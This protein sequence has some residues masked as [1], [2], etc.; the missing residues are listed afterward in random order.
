MASSQGVTFPE[1]SLPDAK[2]WVRRLAHYRKADDLRGI[3]EILVTV[4]P[5]VA[6][7]AAM[8]AA[9]HFGYWIGLV[10]A[11][12]AGGFL[13]RLFV[14]QH[15]CGHGAF[16]GRRLANDWT[17]RGISVLTLTP[18]DFWK[19]VHAMHHAGSGSLDRRGFGDITTLTV[20]EYRRLSTGQRLRYRLYRNPFVLFGIG[21]IYL[22]LFE[23]R[24]PFGMM[25][26]GWR[27]WA[28]TMGTNVAILLAVMAVIWLVGIK[29][30]F[31][32]QL[33][34]TTVAGA[35]GI[36]LF[37]VQHQFEGT[38]WEAGEDWN[39]HEAAFHG[40]SHYDLPLLLRWLTGNIGVHHVHHLCSRI[41]Y[42]RLSAVL[43]DFPELRNVGRLTLLQSIGCV[44]FALWDEQQHRLIS[45]RDER[46]GRQSTAQPA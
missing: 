17:G 46:I 18:Y 30:F 31:L 33:P 26:G 13:V 28:S 43:R 23:Q 21:P 24:L 14:I 44:R 32:I 4:G 1:A 12:P 5:L 37:F 38:T 27:P 19:R 16:F 40:S 6:F 11:I 7:W 9:L 29:L 45:F 8:W 39:W 10:L 25:G 3:F 35:I 34:I 2:V 20:G 36:W 22:F 15:D 42:Y 41:P